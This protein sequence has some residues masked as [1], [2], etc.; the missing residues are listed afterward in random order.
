MSLIT[1][2]KVHKNYINGA[3]CVIALNKLCLTVEEGTFLG[4]MG[5]SGSGKST[6]LSVLGAL[7]SPSS[8]SVIVDGI[9]VYGLSAEKQADFR[10]EY[11]G[12]IFQ[13]HNLIP[14]LNALENVML[15]LAVT[16]FSADEKR[17]RANDMLKRVGLPDRMLHLP[18]QLSGGE[19][20]RV[21]IARALV[22]SPPL[23]LADEPTGSLDTT[24]SHQ[25][26]SLLKELHEDGQTIIMVTHNRENLE[27]FDRTV[28]LRDGKVEKDVQ[29][30]LDQLPQAI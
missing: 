9:D 16:R 28:Y 26:M 3:D 12:F 18:Q 29:S 8:G 21:A 23:L 24:N 25:V 27:W 4:V 30:C 7:A 22:N 11:L 19:Q 14:Y 6:L 1:L 15:P 17:R 10:R 2:D 20:E 5:P 13:S